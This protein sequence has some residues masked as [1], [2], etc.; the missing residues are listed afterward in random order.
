MS[1][2][3][4]IT[5]AK[6]HCKLLLWLTQ[7]NHRTGRGS[8]LLAAGEHSTTLGLLL[9]DLEKGVPAYDSNEANIYLNLISAMLYTQF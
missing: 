6:L 3:D 9:G 4:F 8:S 1:N 5:F 7:V 2:E